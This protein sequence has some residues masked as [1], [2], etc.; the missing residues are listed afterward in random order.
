MIE[1]IPSYSDSWTTGNYRLSYTDLAPNFGGYLQAR[2]V[3]NPITNGLDS[4]QLTSSQF[5]MSK[6]LGTFTAYI[7]LNGFADNAFMRSLSARSN[8]DMS[9][10]ELLD[11][12]KKFNYKLVEK[13]DVFVDV[14]LF[15]DD[16]SITLKTRYKTM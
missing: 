5:A 4:I 16:R 12:L 15:C 3:S 9:V 1:L 6:S 2:L 10:P 14:E 11:I 7:K 8:R 13:R